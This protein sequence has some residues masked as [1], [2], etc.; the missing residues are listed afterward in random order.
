MGRIHAP[1]CGS[2]A[3]AYVERV[4]HLVNTVPASERFLRRTNY[5]FCTNRQK[6]AGEGIERFGGE[7]S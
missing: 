3:P 4:Q 2:I 6:D 7:L 5:E 1:A